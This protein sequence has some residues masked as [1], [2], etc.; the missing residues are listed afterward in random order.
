[1]TTMGLLL[2]VPRRI[3][4]VALIEFRG[5]TVLSQ[6]THLRNLIKLTLCDLSLSELPS[7][8]DLESLDQL[9]ILKV[10]LNV[11]SVGIADAPRLSTRLVLDCPRLKAIPIDFICRLSQETKGPDVSAGLTSLV[12]INLPCEVP[13]EIC[14]P[15]KLKVL[16]T[17]SLSARQITAGIPFHGVKELSF[18]GQLPTASIFT[19]SVLSLYN[20]V[21]LKLEE[22]NMLQMPSLLRCSNLRDVSLIK[23]PILRL[24]IGIADAPR[25]KNLTIQFCSRIEAIDA[26]FIRHLI[27]VTA[28]SRN[29]RRFKMLHIEGLSCLIPNEINELHG[30]EYLW[31][32]YSRYHE[33]FADFPDIGCT[34]TALKVLAALGYPEYN[35]LPED[36]SGLSS[37]AS[38]YFKELTIERLPSSITELHALKNLFL[39]KLHL[40]E[41]PHDLSTL[42]KLEVLKLTECRYLSNIH[43][44]FLRCPR[45]SKV[46]F[47]DRVIH[48]HL[49]QPKTNICF[50]LAQFVPVMRDLPTLRMEGF[51]PKQFKAIVD[52]LQAWPLS[53][54]KEVVFDNLLRPSIDI[55]PTTVAPEDT[56]VH[57]IRESLPNESDK[58]IK[59]KQ[60][61]LKTVHDWNNTQEKV[62]AFC[63]AMNPR[64][65][66]SSP[67]RTLENLTMFTVVDM[68]MGRSAYE[69][70]WANSF[71]MVNRVDFLEEYNKFR[72][73]YVSSDSDG[74][75]VD[76]EN[77]DG[78]NV[79]G[80]D[81]GGNDSDEDDFDSNDSDADIM[82]S[83][84][85]DFFLF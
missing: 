61:N 9:V 30:L 50:K 36:L 68:V 34:L 51:C 33:T 71:A 45:L 84:S 81:S 73:E 76:G 23:L 32:E 46:C 4:K 21:K 7:L 70:K 25:L 79:D 15:K 69:T 14:E 42:S 18:M 49:K 5:I 77:M 17:S 29:P 22:T 60:E 10:L 83:S 66:A 6:L 47:R 27:Q 41:F 75:N 59:R 43:K 16:T 80:N 63:M 38:L 8:A 20:V 31:L 44:G 67:V 24:L 85:A 35:L 52:A 37:L 28:E 78:E 48:R 19:M 57:E 1:M 56:T 64:L 54:T 65:G 82:S 62:M 11:L 58:R 55:D 2:Q 26:V 39:S 3:S 13:A 74:E 53:R 12:M 40:L 72:E